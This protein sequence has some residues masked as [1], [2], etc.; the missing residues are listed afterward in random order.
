[1]DKQ[2]HKLEVLLDFVLDDGHVDFKHFL[3]QARLDHPDQIQV[4]QLAIVRAGSG[5]NKKQK[6]RKR[7]FSVPPGCGTEHR[8]RR[9]RK[10]KEKKR[11]GC[12][13]VKYQRQTRAANL[14]PSVWQAQPTLPKT[15]TVIAA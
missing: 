11:A 3:V 6:K 4:R 7:T 15:G 1:M 13:C 10:K 12:A 9:P 14:D 2:S 8:T 5:T